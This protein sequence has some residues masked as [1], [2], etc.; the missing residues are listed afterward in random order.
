M[1]QQVHPTLG[2]SRPDGEHPHRCSKCSQTIPEDA[3]PL[4]LWGRESFGHMPMWVYCDGC[5][6]DALRDLRALKVE[7]KE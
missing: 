2:V 4:I 6:G 7:G 5:Y 1:T 3:V